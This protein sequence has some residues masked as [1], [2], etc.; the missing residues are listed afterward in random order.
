MHRL[1]VFARIKYLDNLGEQIRLI[2]LLTFPYKLTKSPGIKGFLNF[3]KKV[4]EIQLKLDNKKFEKLKENLKI[5]SYEKG[6]LIFI[7]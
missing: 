6:Q 5:I 3:K 1:S 4:Y 7:D 2:G